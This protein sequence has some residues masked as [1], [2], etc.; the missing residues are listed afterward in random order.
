MTYAPTDDAY[1]TLLQ[2]RSYAAFFT[3]QCITN[4]CDGLLAVTI[5][6]FAIEMN[7]SALQLGAVTF[8]VTLSR[9][10]LGPIG[11]VMGDRMDKRWF[12][13]VVE[14]LR[15][16][17]MLGLFLFYTSGAL[18][19]YSLTAFGI[20]VSTCF[21]IS[22]P[23]AK[24]MIPKLLKEEQLQAGNALVQTITWPAFFLGSG[25]LAGF[26]HFDMKGGIFLA[27]AAAFVVSTA[28]LLLLP[29]INTDSDAPSAKTSLREDLSQGYKELSSDRVL[30]IRVW[31]YAAFTF[32]WRGAL[33]IVLPLLVLRE[34]ESPAWLFGALMFVNGAGEFVGNLVVGRLQLRRPLVFSFLCEPVLGFGLMLLALA[35]FVPY[36]MVPL[37]TGALL[38]GLGAAT[39]DIPLLT[40]I[41]R[42]VSQRNIGKVIS[43]WFTIGSFGGAMG[44]LALGAY[45]EF[46]DVRLGT[47][48]LSI[49]VVLLG[50]AMLNWA[51]RATRQA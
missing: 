4:L 3:S 44:N 16:L 12:L 38:I 37:F 14:L 27:T 28:L 51:Y 47:T 5:I 50:L 45:F 35:L 40:V 46:L 39:I 43:Y 25:L 24:S 23:A 30:L 49:G 19:I 41:Q 2:R 32:F 7:A 42:H 26:L 9:G 36:P 33:Q 6:Y 22:V 18:N 34:L 1:L 11:G 31:S 17:L 15:A 13:I 29:E 48:I 21:A 20:L 10:F 8:G